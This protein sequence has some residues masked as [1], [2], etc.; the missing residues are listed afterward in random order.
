LTPCLTDGSGLAAQKTA[1]MTDMN[2]NDLELSTEPLGQTEEEKIESLMK[3][4]L[5]RKKSLFI[6]KM[7]SHEAKGDAV[8]VSVKE[9]QRD[10]LA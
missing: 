6:V 4:G 9:H 7:R 3:L 2:G 8:D 1:G 10:K 5:S